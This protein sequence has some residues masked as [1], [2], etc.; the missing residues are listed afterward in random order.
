[1]EQYRNISQSNYIPIPGPVTITLSLQNALFFFK[2]Y[3]AEGVRVRLGIRLPNTYIQKFSSKFGIFSEIDLRF[4]EMERIY[5]S[6][7]V[8]VN[9]VNSFPV[10]Y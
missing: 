3:N 7:T 10:T 2:D 8:L 5:Q 6:L 1:M 9:Y 4:N